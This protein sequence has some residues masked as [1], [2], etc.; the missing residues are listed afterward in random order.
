M[1]R[2]TGALCSWALS[3][4]TLC[5]GCGAGSPTTPPPPERYRLV[6]SAGTSDI[7]ALLVV[8]GGTSGTPTVLSGATTFSRISTGAGS[9]VLMVGQLAGR[10]LLEVGTTAP[11]REPSATVLD[12]SGG[13]NT[14]YARIPNSGISVEWRPVE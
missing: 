11:G 10:E 7:R 4:A 3:A 13:S 2:R 12:A 5:L 14:S 6:V 9:R 1:T 8:L